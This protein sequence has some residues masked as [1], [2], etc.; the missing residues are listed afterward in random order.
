MVNN[1]AKL[2][3]DYSS[4]HIDKIFARRSLY[5]ENVVH[6][7]LPLGFIFNLALPRF[8]GECF[9]LSEIS[10]NFIK[11][12]FVG[13][14]LRIQ[15][16]VNEAAGKNNC[17]TLEYV[18]ENTISRA[19]LIAGIFTLVRR[20]AVG[21]ANLPVKSP[22]GEA[23]ALGV[24]LEEKNLIWEQI[25]L[26]DKK[27]FSFT[28]TQQCLKFFYDILREGMVVVGQQYS[29]RGYFKPINFLAGSLMSTFAGMC[30]PGRSATILNIGI[31]FNKDL[32]VNEKY[33]FGGEVVFKSSANTITD[34]VSIS[35]NDK[36]NIYAGGKINIKVNRQPER[37]PASRQ[38]YG[39]A[40]DLRLKD[41]VVLV[42]GASRGIGEVTAKLFAI[43]GCK[44][45]VN[46]AQ[47]K[48]D[49][50]RVVADI[51]DAGGEVIAVQADVS[52][53][54]QVRRMVDEVIAKYGTINVLVNNAVRNFRPIAF[55][56]LTWEEIQK[57]IDVNLKGAFYCSQAAI[58]LMLTA[59]GGRIINISSIA[60]DNPPPNQ[61]KYVI[62]K[63]GLIGL[64]RSLAAEFASNDILVNMVVPNMVKTDLTAGIAE[65]F[66]DAAAKDIPLK[67][68]A[69]PIDVARAVVY[70]ASSWSSYTTGQ[71]IMVTG[72]SLPF[73]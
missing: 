55:L 18:V 8:A 29:C 45:V 25:Q 56:E 17:L 39:A 20:K 73:L 4:L 50:L 13:D 59:G 52:D 32:S 10:A 35:S 27:A 72:G 1:F 49:A 36:K 44:V 54:S 2:T 53:N 33:C 9:S 70:L 24:A 48:D 23:A 28:I 34:K 22:N 19:V 11:P 62:S 3:G 6:G 47:N 15:A 57:D 51:K 5:R 46:Y 71:R 67:R 26:H 69:S 21:N 65:S 43:Y 61:A 66:I 68:I 60:T 58:P 14:K 12:I 38:L 37:M 64:T 42:T 7:L 16:T 31:A 41:R 63:S 40:L 30:I